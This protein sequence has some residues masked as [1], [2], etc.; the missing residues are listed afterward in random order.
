MPSRADPTS[1]PWIQTRLALERTLLAWLRTAAA[2][3]G[4]GFAIFEFYERLDMVPGV[5]PALHP[6]T[7]RLLGVTLVGIGT[8]ALALSLVQYVLL[9]RSLGEPPDPAVSGIPRFHPGRTVA[10]VLLAVGAVT[11]WVLLNRLPF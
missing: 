11:F 6:G 1:Y 8:L 2:L 5:K 10:I 9:V 4:F 7:S 3:I